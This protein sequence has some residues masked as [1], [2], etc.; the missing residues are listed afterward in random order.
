MKYPTATPLGKFE[1][2]Y[3]NLRLELIRGRVAA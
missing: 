3:R 2:A 1:N